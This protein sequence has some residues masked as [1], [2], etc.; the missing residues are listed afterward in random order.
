MYQGLEEEGQG[1]RERQRQRQKEREEET[2]MEWQVHLSGDWTAKAS[3]ASSEV[4]YP[5]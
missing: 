4:R 1:R 3:V 5:S 2:G